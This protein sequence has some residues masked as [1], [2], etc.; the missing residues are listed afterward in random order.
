MCRQVQTV[1]V[2]KVIL[3]KVELQ[4]CAPMALWHTKIDFPIINN[5]PSFESHTT[6]VRSGYVFGPIKRLTNV[7]ECLPHISIPSVS[8]VRLHPW[9][10]FLHTMIDASSFGPLSTRCLHP[11]SGCLYSCCQ[12]KG[13]WYHCNTHL[14]R[15]H[16]KRC[17]GGF[18]RTWCKNVQNNLRKTLCE[19][20]TRPK[21]VSHQKQACLFRKNCEEI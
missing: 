13:S 9:K 4:S 16:L 15:D 14:H 10:S 2:A 18:R 19:L 11:F 20:V 17:A 7:P 12:C 21:S 6:F 1:A 3:A 5:K 8:S